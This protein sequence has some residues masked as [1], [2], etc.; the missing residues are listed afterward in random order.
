MFFHNTRLPVEKM[1]EL[2]EALAQSP[3]A[4]IGYAKTD[5]ELAK[6]LGLEIAVVQNDAL[7]AD[8]EATLDHSDNP[9]Y[10]GLI[11][12]KQM[13]RRSQFACIHEIIHYVFDVGTGNYVQQCY[14]RK[15]RGRTQ[16]PHEQEIN[17][18]TA[19]YSMPYDQIKEAIRQ[20]N[21][22]SP[23]MDELVFI[24]DLCRHYDQERETVLR[25]IREVKRIARCR[26]NKL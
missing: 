26:G 24:H 17:Y 15:I 18:M 25:R 13:Y 12:V 9:D 10:F 8:T 14:A 23:R 5:V 3:L 6:I 16:S 2:E 19:S 21:A 4:E 22:S 20:Y 1:V 11:Q 7:P